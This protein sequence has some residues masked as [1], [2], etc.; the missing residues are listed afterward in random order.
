MATIDIAM[1]STSQQIL[2]KL[3]TSSGGGY[4]SGIQIFTSNGTF[5]VPENVGVIYI[6]ACGGG[7]GGAG[8]QNSYAGGGGG[9][10]GIIYKYPAFV[11]PGQQIAITV[12]AGGAGGTGVTNTTSASVL[13]KAG[14]STVIGDLITVPGGQGGGA[15]TSTNSAGTKTYTAYYGGAS[16]GGGGTG[17]AGAYCSSNSTHVGGR[18]GSSI[19]FRNTLSTDG[20]P[21]S[22]GDQGVDG[23]IQPRSP[24]GASGTAFCGGGGGA[25]LGGAGGSGANNG[26]INS[27]PK[28]GGAA[29]AN[30]GAGGGGAGS[31]TYGSTANINGGKGGSGIVFIEW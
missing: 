20:P 21:I 1:E 6:S 3:N 29:A 4:K 12:G 25:S 30:T 16:W 22:T 15:H 26:N 31:T 17:G 23:S 27:N 10:G 5:T 8:G 19:S 18:G 14:G 28:P 24:G 13:G 9:G 2:N 7:G 11:T